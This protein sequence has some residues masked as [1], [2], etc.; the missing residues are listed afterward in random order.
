MHVHVVLIHFVPNICL[1]TAAPQ[2]DQLGSV[3]DKM[4]FEVSILIDDVIDD[5]VEVDLEVDK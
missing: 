2:G 3:T 4:K 1:D 5:V